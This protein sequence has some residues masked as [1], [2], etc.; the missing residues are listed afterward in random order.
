MTI[1]QASVLQNH[2]TKCKRAV[3][4][5]LLL[6]VLALLGWWALYPAKEEYAA[7]V[8][9]DGQYRVVVFRKAKWPALMPGQAGDAPG[10]VELHDRNGILI[11]ETAVEMVQL[12]ENV[13]W[14]EKKVQIKLVVEWDLPN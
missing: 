4:A 12:V 9:P 5:V 10:T 1:Q 3:A 6:L 2:R 13:V 11:K 14:L 8:R 7:F